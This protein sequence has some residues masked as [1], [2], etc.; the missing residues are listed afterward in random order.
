MNYFPLKIKI[1]FH[2][3]QKYPDILQKMRHLIYNYD[4][5]HARI[6][7]WGHILKYILIFLMPRISPGHLANSAVAWYVLTLNI[8]D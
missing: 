1:E 4:E 6:L 3:R 2:H 7:F 8:S 5:L